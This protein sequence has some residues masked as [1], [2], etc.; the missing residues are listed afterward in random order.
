MASEPTDESLSVSL[1]SDLAE[2]IDRQAADRGAD[3]ETVLVQLLAAHRAADEMDDGVD[4]GSLDGVS[5]EDEVRSVIAE[6]MN[7]IAGAVAEQL[8]VERKVEDAIE[9]RSSELTQSA[10]DRATRQVDNELTTLES[11]FS[12]NLDDVRDRVI[13]V[14][15]ETDRKAP[16]EHDHPDLVDRLNRLESDVDA[17]QDDL[18]DLRADLDGQFDS[19][20]QRLD[21]LDETVWDLQDKLETVAYVVRD[22]RDGSEMENKRAASVDAIKQA[23][24]KEDLDRARC[25]ACGEGVEI[26]LMTGPECP[27][28]EA[29]VTD[30]RPGEGL[31]GKPMLVKAQGIEPA[32]DEE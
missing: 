19:Q 28:C 14:K 31:F 27:H 10:V 32:D 2:W 26:G 25:E 7:D 1:P 9:A 30:V 18:D 4:V 16:A 23:A 13:Q 15:K 6:R 8:A 5:V 21:E 11:E 24:A 20:E 22:L 29:T 17:V 12:E 3:R